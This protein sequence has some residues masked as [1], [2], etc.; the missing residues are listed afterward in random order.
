MASGA[1]GGTALPPQGQLGQAPLPSLVGHGAAYGGAAG[2]YSGHVAARGHPLPAMSAPGEHAGAGYY[3]GPNSNSSPAAEPN[4]PASPPNPTK[5]EMRKLRNRESAKRSRENAKVRLVAL[6]AAHEEKKREADSLRAEL[7]RLQYLARGNAQGD[8]SAAASGSPLGLVAAAAAVASACNRDEDRKDA[9]AAQVGQVSDVLVQRAQNTLYLR[10]LSECSMT[11]DSPSR[12]EPL[13]M[14]ERLLTV[15]ED[16]CVVSIQGTRESHSALQPLQDGIHPGVS[17]FEN[18]DAR[19]K[20]FLHSTWGR[21]IDFA[22]RREFPQTLEVLTYARVNKENVANAINIRAVVQP[23]VR[24]H[25][26]EEVQFLVAE[27]RRVP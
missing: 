16:G 1:P 15:A 25:M 5:K 6:Q 4:D 18:V 17:F 11:L 27:F 19:W 20:Q 24:E 9:L 21:Y 2:Y 13:G 23:V 14:L 3:S 12:Q 10:L 7:A 22:R 8:L 26:A